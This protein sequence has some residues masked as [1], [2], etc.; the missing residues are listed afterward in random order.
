MLHLPTFRV[1]KEP[2][3]S[4]DK[5][6]TVILITGASGRIGRR[7]AAL[8]ASDGHRLRLMSR[9]PER[10]PTLPAAETIYGDFSKP[11]TLIAAFE[12]ATKALIISGSGKPGERALLHNNAFQAAKHAQVQHV[13][14][15]SL[16]GAS[17]HSKYPF[18]RDHYVSEQYLLATGVPSTIL[19]NAFYIDMFLDKFDADGIVRGP[20]GVGKG[21]FVSRE[22]VARTAA[23][24]LLTEASGILEVTG[25]ESLTVAEV[26]SRFSALTDRDLRFENEPSDLMRKRLSKDE[27]VNSAID[28]AVGWFEAIAAGELDHISDTVLRLTGRRPLSIEDYFRLFPD[29]LRAFD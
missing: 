26:T 20:A 5:L 4:R 6:G 2:Q 11:A 14:Y 7:V 15:L 1:P 10:V 8:L 22:D 17:P 21:A 29:L 12:G 25:R 27:P 23:S 3:G 18:S 24:A 19:R 28:L 13:V 16:L 9:T